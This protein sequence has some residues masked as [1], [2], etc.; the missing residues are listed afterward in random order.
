MIAIAIALTV[1]LVAGLPIG[2][3]FALAGSFAL[4]Y[5]GEQQLNV[6]SRLFSGL[7]TFVL[8][9]A[10]FYI[11]A[12]ELM[13]RGGISERLIHLAQILIGRVRGG[14]AYAAILASVMF[15]GI[16]GTAVADIAALGNI[17]INGM[18]KEGYSKSF[19][20]AVTV[21]ASV[22]G[23]II[24]PSVIM[25]LYAA[26]ANISVLDLFI[27]GIIPG[28]LLGVACA[29]VVFWRGRRGDMPVSTIVV[30][31][32]EVPRLVRDGLLVLSLPGFIVLGTLS[33]AFTPT[34][35]GGVAVVY[36]AF[37]G[38]FVFHSLTFAGFMRAARNSARM[39]AGLFL[40]IAAV[41][42]VNYV[43]I[44]AG[45]GEAT[46]AIVSVFKDY[47]NTFLLVCVVAFLVIGLALDAG[48]ALLLLAPVLLPITR[49][50]GIDDMHFS[51]V[52]IVSVTLGL[53]SPPV[54]ICLFV[55]CKIGNITMRMLW[56]ELALF[57]Y[58]EIALIVVLV[59]FPVLSN[60]LPNLLRGAG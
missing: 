39:T 6:I 52:M 49:N 10:P 30:Q 22:I 2:Y 24:P 8:M 14:T 43:L 27:A 55:A 41:E 26:V 12:G 47:P 21:A 5:G 32:A 50:M 56:S 28:L 51:M 58:A 15:S 34:E 33:G 17:F 1:L 46:G 23:P 44:L 4:W 20:A 7:D 48:P 13:N 54:G 40:L 53:I 16:S 25:V 11:F 42:V 45:V 38:T 35:A 59:Y 3:S 18:A 36:A 19:A 9:A 31:R 29:L 60:G 57:F 37:L